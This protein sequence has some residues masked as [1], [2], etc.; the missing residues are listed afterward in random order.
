[1]KQIVVVKITDL[2]YGAAEIDNP[3]DS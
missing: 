1:M 2:S 3:T